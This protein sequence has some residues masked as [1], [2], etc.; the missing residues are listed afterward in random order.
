MNLKEFE[1]LY[2][3]YQPVLVNFAN[4]YLKNEQ[5]SIDIVQELFKSLWEKRETLI[6]PSSPKSYLLKAV[7]NR[8]YNKLTRNKTSNTEIEHL[9]NIFVEN[10]TPADILENRQAAVQIDTLIGKLPEKCREIFILSRFENMSYKEIASTLDI[11]SK[12]V[13]NQIGNALKFL[14]KNYFKILLLIFSF[15]EN[16]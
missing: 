9:E 3:T 13:E 12:T 6:L 11:S 4:F 2:K 14:R 10:E 16:I 1:I 8:C 7:K 15:L 5:D